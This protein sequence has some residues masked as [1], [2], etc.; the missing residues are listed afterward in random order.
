MSFVRSLRGR[1]IIGAF[2][3]TMGLLSMAG[4]VFTYLVSVRPRHIVFLH[5]PFTHVIFVAVLAIVLLLGGLFYFR[6]GVSPITQLR[7]HLSLVHSGGSRRVEGDFPSEIEPLITDLNAL[8]AHHEQAITRAQSKAGDLAHGLKTP[9]AVLSK[10]AADADVAGH[11]ALAES[12]RQQ[13]DRMRRQID[14]HLASARAAASGAT[15]QARCVVAESV[16]GLVRTVAR[17]YA[18][19]GITIEAD[20]DPSHVVRV[21]R[22]D[23]DEMVGNLLDNACKWARQQVRVSVVSSADAVRIM[24]DDDGPGVPPERRVEVLQRGVR[25]DQNAPGSGFG[26]AIVSDLAEIYG[27]TISLTDA[28]IGGTCAVLTLP[29]APQPAIAS[30]V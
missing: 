19:R 21:Q 22:E 4:I 29:S 23:L 17:I 10:E 1:V 3:W 11:A 28:P 30:N 26:L 24:V 12:I 2:L 14:Y 7:R 5:W 9:L 16:D 25:A 6:Q 8:L 20:V 27:G 15:M 13:I 18:E